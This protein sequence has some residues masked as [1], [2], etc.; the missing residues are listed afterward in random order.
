MRDKAADAT[1][2]WEFVGMLSRADEFYME[3][4][5]DK[6]GWQEYEASEAFVGLLRNLYEFFQAIVK[7]DEREILAEGCGVRNHVGFIIDN[8]AREELEAIQDWLPVLE[9]IKNNTAWYGARV[10][11][12]RSMPVEHNS[13]DSGY[14]L[15]EQRS[16][17]G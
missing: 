12:E 8:M 17:H 7:G 15:Y 4:H 14:E 1:K 3:L 9:R 2:I 6:G 10:E 13:N 11:V 5:R 16:K